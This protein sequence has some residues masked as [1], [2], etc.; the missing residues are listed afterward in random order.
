MIELFKINNDVA[1]R[2]PLDPS[3]TELE[4][5]RGCQYP[6]Q[7]D[8]LG[9]KIADE[10]GLN[11]A[12]NPDSSALVYFP[13]SQPKIW[14]LTL[15]P[16]PALPSS[17]RRVATDGSAPL[18]LSSGSFKPPLSWDPSGQKV[19]VTAAVT[20]HDLAADDVLAEVLFTS[21]H[22]PVLRSLPAPGGLVSP[23]GSMVAREVF[24]G[25]GTQIFSLETGQKLAQ[26]Q[27]GL[28]R[29]TSD[30]TGVLTKVQFSGLEG[31]GTINGRT[32]WEF[33][34]LTSRGTEEVLGA[35]PTH[36]QFPAFPVITAAGL[37]IFMSN[38]DLG[39]SLISPEDQP[40]VGN[41]IATNEGRLL[42]QFIRTVDD[43]VNPRAFVWVSKCKG[44]FETYCHSELLMVSPL[45]GERRVVAS[46]RVP[47]E[48][49]PSPDG[50]RIAIVS[51]NAI[52]VKDLQ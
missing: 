28:L 25:K 30:N 38:I 29:W 19:F 4:F 15:R 17:I 49:A 39:L 20:A 47:G 40:L 45:T 13:D 6:Q 18:T 48:V 9:M 42:P 43:P 34:K 46:A 7:P 36:V 14:S 5:L 37:K 27:P 52:F 1:E 24:G 16:T 35:F 41:V 51:G 22:G 33:R 21:D 23:D 32:N 11:L 50:K 8:D 2:D 44:L 10:G 31:N 3:G 26:G 12:W